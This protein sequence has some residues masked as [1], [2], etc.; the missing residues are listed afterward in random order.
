MIIYSASKTEFFNDVISNNIE[1]I[2]YDKTLKRLG[3]KT[4]ASEIRSWQNSLMYMNNILRDE[5][6]PQDSMV[7]IEYKIPK[8]N[9][10]IDFIISGLNEKKESSLIIVELK[11]WEEAKKTEKND[12]VKVRFGSG[13][14]ETPH[15]SYQAWSYAALLEDYNSAVQEEKI[16]IL[17]CAYLHN[18]K[19]PGALNDEFYSEYIHKAPIFYRSDA[20]ELTS[21]IKKHVKYGDTDGILY[22]IEN[23]KIRPSKS[24]SDELQSM[25]QGNQEF[26]LIDDQKVIVENAVYLASQSHAKNKNVLIV[27][28]GPGSGK[29]VVAINLLNRLTQ[30]GQTVQYVSKNAAPRAVYERKLS[31][32]Y[33]KSRISNMF[34]GS[35]VF[36]DCDQNSIDSL[37]VDE[38]HRLNAKSG[39]FS[40]LGE[41]Q[42]KEIIRSSFFSIFFLDE[43]QKVTFKDIGSKEQ[44]HYWASKEKAKVSELKLTSQFRCNGSDGYIAWLDQVLQV[45]ETA[46]YDMKELN[47]EFKVFDSPSKLH[48]EIIKNNKINNKSRVVAGY[49]WEWPSKKTPKKFDIE[50]EDDFKVRWNLTSH[51]SAWIINSESVTEAGC[52]HTC[53][54]LE[55][56]YVGVIIGPDFVVRDGKVITDGLK[57]AKSDQ[58]IKG[59]KTKLKKSPELAKSEVDVIIKNTYRTLMTRGMK[60]CYLYCTDPETRDYFRG[61]LSENI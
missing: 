51:G 60:G 41:N 21:F 2:L 23:G 44:I 37:I 57:R 18:C 35:G 47:Y 33:T 6:I 38:A 43:N 34:K 61:M 52:I 10:Q 30:L 9:R 11:Q 36:H 42:I 5:D 15:P 25:L 13:E 24:L 27:E 50:L 26:V 46:N 58:S 4:A 45:S 54:G 22:K 53:Q 56:D 20:N 59:F 55:L 32:S 28:G 49:C 3:Q 17:P 14:V 19:V 29:S 40:N 39:M 48:N 31:G 7:A 12:L 16:T 8:T 1:Q